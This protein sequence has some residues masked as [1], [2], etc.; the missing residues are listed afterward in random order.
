[1]TSDLRPEVEIWP[2]CAC[3]MKKNMQYDRYYRNNSVIVDL[4]L[5]Q[6]PRST[7]RI[8][9]ILKTFS[10]KIN[11]PIIMAG[12]ISHAHAS[13]FSTP[14]SFKTRKFWRFGHK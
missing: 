1:M 2:F 11:Q 4:T 6:I 5:G 14:I 8:S 3:A 7:E 9:S 10:F 12:C 13:C